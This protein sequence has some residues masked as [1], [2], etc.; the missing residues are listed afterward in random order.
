MFKLTTEL[1]NISHFNVVEADHFT[2]QLKEGFIQKSKK[3][4]KVD[5]ILCVYRMRFVTLSKF[6]FM[7]SQRNISNYVTRS[8][9]YLIHTGE[10]TSMLISKIFLYD[11]SVINFYLQ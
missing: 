5:A 6:E 2:V 1:I 9:N 8:R 4:L 3:V 11:A 10:N 7:R